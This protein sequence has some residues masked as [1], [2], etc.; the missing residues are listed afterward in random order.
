MLETIRSRQT[1]MQVASIGT[2]PWFLANLVE[3]YGLHHRENL[4]E[5]LGRSLRR[6]G[7]EHEAASGESIFKALH[8]IRL[9]SSVLFQPWVGSLSPCI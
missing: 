8:T 9:R 4:L 3:G 5:Y 2:P 7:V 6:H 1:T